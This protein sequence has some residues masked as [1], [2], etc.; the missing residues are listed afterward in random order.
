MAEIGLTETTLT[1]C[2]GTAMASISP[3]TMRVYEAKITYDIINLGTVEPLFGPDKVLRYMQG[4]FD[5][6]PCQES[7]WVVALD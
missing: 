4:A 6:H 1:R 3:A 7:F 5:S 2:G